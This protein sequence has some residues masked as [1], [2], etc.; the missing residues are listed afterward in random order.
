MANARPTIRCLL[1]DLRSDLGN[2]DQRSGLAS[3]SLRGLGK[4]PLRTIDHPLLEKV[5]ML[6]DRPIAEL[7]ERRI[8]AVTDYVW[9]R[10]KAGH[11]RGAVWI[12]KPG[13]PWL[14]AAGI[15]RDGD[16]SDFYADFERRC[17]SGSDVF[18]PSESD[19]KRL[20]WRWP[21]RMTRIANGR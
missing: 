8:L 9:Y 13:V 20:D 7:H 19:S 12:D 16:T 17:V 3:G 2:A 18:L 5:T 15:R 21:M 11:F 10:V 4:V 14:C 1:D 6:S